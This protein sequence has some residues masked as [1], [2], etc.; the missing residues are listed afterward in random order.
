MGG[1][2]VKLAAPI[3]GGT[4][5]GAA[6]WGSVYRHM[7]V[8]AA[9]AF[10]NCKKIECRIG[11]AV[12]IGVLLHDCGATRPGSVPPSASSAIPLRMVRSD[13]PAASATA[14]MRPR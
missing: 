13:I 9:A 12:L 2:G 3:S 7:H 4:P 6:N 5:H 8:N 10:R 11:I 1:Y 14:A